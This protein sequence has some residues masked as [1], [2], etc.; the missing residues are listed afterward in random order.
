VAPASGASRSV[1]NCNIIIIQ[2]AHVLEGIEQI[3]MA[4]NRGK[5]DDCSRWKWNGIQIG[6]NQF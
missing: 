2:E 1:T 5:P 4:N 3:S 6:V